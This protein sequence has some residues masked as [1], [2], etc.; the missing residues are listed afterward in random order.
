[1]LLYHG[2][3]KTCNTC[4]EL[5]PLS[6]FR[7]RNKETGHRHNGCNDCLAAYRRSHYLKNRQKYIDKSKQANEV[8]RRRNRTY[9]YNWLTSHPCVDCGESDIEVLEFDHVEP[10]K[11][12]G[13]RVSDYLTCSLSRLEAE[14]AKCEVRCANCHTRRTRRMQGWT[15]QI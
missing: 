2:D 4:K 1:M 3:M 14:I 10:L 11:R 8:T 13:G 12:R 7:L 9:L 15:Y 6:E 5:K